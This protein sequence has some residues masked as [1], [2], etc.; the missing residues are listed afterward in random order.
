[1]IRAL[2]CL[3]LF[4]TSACISTSEMDRDRAYAE[5]RNMPAKSKRDACIA[6]L[7]QQ[8]ER[9]RQADAERQRRAEEIAE[10]R[11]LNRVIGGVDGN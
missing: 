2:A 10:Q 7:I 6:D 1:M 3:A 11:E 4:S 9:E 8:A 5:C